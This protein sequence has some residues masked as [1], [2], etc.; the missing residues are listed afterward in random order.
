MMSTKIKKIAE[1]LIE[2]A[3]AYKCGC[4]HYYRAVTDVP[5]IIWQED[6]EGESLHSNNLK[7]EQNVEGTV[8]FFTKTEFDPIVDAIQ[9]ALNPVCAFT[10]NSVQYESETNLIHY[11]WIWHV[12]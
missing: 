12:I 4:Y 6:G 3:K 10:L 2:V 1:A 9:D 7:E 8:D 11:E 5:V